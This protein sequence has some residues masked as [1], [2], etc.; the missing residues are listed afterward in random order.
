MKHSAEKTD[1]IITK[2]FEDDFC[3]EAT[4]LP[5]NTFDLIL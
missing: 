4:I 3:V 1:V 5:H 2:K